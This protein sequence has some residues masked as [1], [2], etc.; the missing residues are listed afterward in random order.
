MFKKISSSIWTLQNQ[1]LRSARFSSQKMQTETKQNVSYLNQEV[2]KGVD[3]QL[4]EEYGWS[5]D[6]LMELAGRFRKTI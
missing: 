6:S 1:F 4:M 5:L 3:Q 2:A